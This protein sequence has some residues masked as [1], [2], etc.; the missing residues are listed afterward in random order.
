MRNIIIT[1]III[2]SVSSAF[3]AP[4]D[5]KHLFRKIER[6]KRTFDRYNDSITAPFE[7]RESWVHL[8]LERAAVNSRI[9][10]ENTT[11]IGTILTHILSG[12][13]DDDAHVEYFNCLKDMF[14]KSTGDIFLVV[15]LCEAALPFFEQNSG[16]FPYEYAMLNYIYGRCRYEITLINHKDNGSAA[17][18]ALLTAANIGRALPDSLKE[19]FI[20]ALSELAMVVWAR[21]NQEALPVLYDSKRE[22]DS[23]MSDTLITKHL[24]PATEA[25][26]NSVLDRFRYNV[27]RN[28]HIQGK[29]G[30][31]ENIGTRITDALI[32]DYESAPS[33]SKNEFS[34]MMLFKY[35]R[36]KIS[37]DSALTAS[38]NYY[39]E[40]I[41]THRGINSHDLYDLHSPLLNITYFNDLS[42]FTDSVKHANAIYITKELLRLFRLMKSNQSD[43][44]PTA[45]LRKFVTYKRLTSHLTSDE[46][47][48]FIMRLMVTTQPATYAHSVHVGALAEIIFAGVENHEPDLL[49]DNSAIAT[50]WKT[51]VREA[52]LYHDLGK[53]FIFPIITNEYRP[54][55]TR[56]IDII[57]DHPRLGLSVMDIDSMLSPY[58]DITLGHHRWYNGAGGYPSD[59]DN[60]NSMMKFIVDVM[61]VCD[62]LEA[63]TDLV[64]RNYSKNKKLDVL[65]NEMRKE[66][67]TRYNPKVLDIITT[68]PEVY[69][70]LKKSIEH[71]WKDI[72]YNI[73][74][75]YIIVPTI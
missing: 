27:L 21:R 20:G 15:R 22:L 38:L 37:A 17:Y 49:P 4:P 36:G 30:L 71:D 16:R 64:G 47:I 45:V 13:A 62:C 55:S 14:Y 25:R 51:F 11:T 65:I 10:A 58:H 28:L 19:P 41:R 18:N 24:H 42:S 57:K 12:E 59:F 60:S 74:E 35:V 56:E 70:A 34:Q 61:T 9:Y 54:L 50:D 69:D 40:H 43:N 48:D 33:L 5:F 63:A 8:F 7:D 6:T 66:A 39:R 3:G 29:A 2:L 26:A 23:Y 53:C 32:A 67:G 68:Y 46:K 1:I 31:P 52:A 72:Y 73:Y 44:L 75:K